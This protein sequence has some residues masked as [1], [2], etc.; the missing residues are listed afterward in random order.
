MKFFIDT[1]S[2]QEIKE[3]SELGI[4]EGVTTNP[5]LVAKEGKNFKEIILEIAEIIN[6]PISAEATALDAEEMVK[7][8]REFASWSKNIVVKIPMTEEGI[9][10]VRKLSEEDIKTNVTLVF[11]V[12]QA[13]L[14]AKA[15]QPT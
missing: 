11:S 9:K 8:A 2:V 3:A 1:A 12:N 5:S 13:L 10:A 14:A 7:Q 4:I 15:A 6:G